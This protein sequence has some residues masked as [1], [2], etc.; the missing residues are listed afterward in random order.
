MQVVGTF[1]LALKKACCVVR[2][3]SHS[4]QVDLQLYDYS[5]DIWSLGCMLAGMVFRKEPFFH[6]QDNYDQLVKIARVLGTDGLFA[7][8]DKY[9]QELDPHF[10]HILGRPASTATCRA[11]TTDINRPHPLLRLVHLNR[12]QYLRP[13]PRCEEGGGK[14]HRTNQRIRKG[15][16]RGHLEITR[17]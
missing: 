11:V 5:L 17:R 12:V 3:I 4:W 16:K 7:Y 8:L 15:S 13:V 1:L 10:D 2:R 6:G 9:N 14:K